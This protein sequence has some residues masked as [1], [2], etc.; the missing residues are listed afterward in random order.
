M[1]ETTNEIIGTLLGFIMFYCYRLFNNYGLAIIA[2]TII[3]KVI[4]IPISIWIHKNS[5]KIVKIQPQIN[6]I[7]A[8]YFGDNDRIADEQSKLYKKVGYKPL[9]NI[10]P[11]V[12]QIILLI[13]VIHVIYHP[14]DY[15]LNLETP[16]INEL[17]NQT[18]DLT[19]ID[20]SNSTIQLKVIEA[21]KNPAFKD[22]FS[23]LQTQIANVDVEKIINR[24]TSVN[25]KFLGLNLSWIPI[26]EKGFLYAVPIIAG[27]FAWLLSYIQ[28]RINVL[29]SEQGIFNKSFTMLLSVGLSLY[30]GLFVPLGVALYWI[31][32]NILGII[33][34]L[35]LNEMINP[36]KFIDYEALE[37]SK[38]K[39]DELNKFKNKKTKNKSKLDKRREREDYNRFFSIANKHLVFYSEGSGYY[40][41]FKNIIEELLN[42]S[43][44]V[45]HYVT[46]DSKD[47]IFK[48]ALSQ[49]KIKPY[50]IG[51]KRLIV[52]M[53][54][55]DSEVVVMTTPDLGNFHIKRSHIKKD[56]EYIYIPHSPGGSYSKTL[57]KGALDNFDTIFLTG[58]QAKREIRAL[59]KVYNLP[60]KK[61]VEF[62]FPLLEDIVKNYESSE[63]ETNQRKVILIAPSWHEGN[64]MESCIEPILEKLTSGEYKIIVR[65]HPQYTRNNEE[66]VKRLQ[67]EFSYVSKDILVF[68]TDFSSS[69][70]I[71]QSDIIVTDWSGIGYEFCYST[72]RPGL[73]VNT[74]RKIMNPEYHKVDLE[75]L[76]DRI[77]KKMGIELELN[78]ISSIEEKISFLLQNAAMYQDI[79]KDV[80][81]SELYNFGYSAQKGAEYIIDKLIYKE[82]N[83]KEL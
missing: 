2:F 9:A 60:Q 15:L 28:N 35:V 75:T 61:F 1:F 78:E 54:R 27:F 22:A 34:L 4:L 50:Y 49:P 11:L 55:M 39:L 71:F 33:Q 37:A 69:S 66:E 79:I 48:I 3:T 6:F 77:R 63:R 38:I 70:S 65:P 17:V 13:G 51:M 25:M 57:R 30:L 10:I 42:R 74:K 82:N 24:I 19:N 44:V 29:Q 16:V 18:I 14:L 7:K 47:Q 26:T 80:R 36:K 8:K 41:Y 53:M 58:P 40:K 64:I 45:I 32:R 72:L 67:N 43:N 68:E 46:N 83:K 12:I 76:E 20:L 23:S 31:M 56:I 73:F 5:I 81:N 21:V 62:G 59:E 52:L